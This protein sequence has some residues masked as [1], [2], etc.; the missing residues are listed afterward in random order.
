M[1]TSMETFV[2]I[3][4]ETSEKNSAKTSGERILNGEFFEDACQFF[5]DDFCDIS[6]EDF[7]EGKGFCK[8]FCEQ[9]SCDFCGNPCTNGFACSLLFG[10]S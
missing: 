10:T 1:K 4:M 2:K 7:Y 5:C 8:D 6:C 9:F 3:F